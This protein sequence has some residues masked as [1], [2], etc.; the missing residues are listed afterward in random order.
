[1]MFHAPKSG[2]GDGAGSPP[3]V[4]PYAGTD[5]LGPAINNLPAGVPLTAV[6][7]ASSTPTADCDP[8]SQV[9]HWY[10]YIPFMATSDCLASF[11]TG[12]RD[13]ASAA[14]HEVGAATAAVATGAAAGFAKG[15]TDSPGNPDNPKAPGL[16][17]TTGLMFAAVGGIA[18]LALL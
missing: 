16:S 1:M 13:L 9:C 12:T 14:T 15:L 5:A 17:F 10:C 2:L 4:D 11:N 18:A 7:L 3:V 6:D 8:T